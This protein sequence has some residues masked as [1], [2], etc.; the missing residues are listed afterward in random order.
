[1]N[2]E[3]M[4]TGLQVAQLKLHDRILGHATKDSGNKERLP[5]LT[6]KGEPQL[7]ITKTFFVMFT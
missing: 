1:M 4:I 2:H 5:L 3:G 6:A 7:N